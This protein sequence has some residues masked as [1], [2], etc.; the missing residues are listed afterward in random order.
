MSD[1]IRKQDPA[2]PG[3]HV[4][5]WLG[6]YL[7]GE[8]TAGM[9][10][11]IEAHLLNCV[12]CQT[13]LESL[14]QLSDLLHADPPLKPQGSDRAFARKIVEQIRRPARPFWQRFLQLSWRMA[15]LFLF[16]GWAFFQAV[17]WISGLVLVGMNWVPGIED[18]WQAMA[19]LPNDGGLLFSKL[20]SDLLRM[21]LS[22]LKIG[23]VAESIAWLEPVGVM[24]LLNLALLTILAVL[25]VSWLASLWAYQ[26][27]KTNLKED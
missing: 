24:A 26:Q 11:Q 1:L 25:F 5:P 27:A 2:N 21:S 3:D 14:E 10:E 4:T 19:P 13:E 8:V 23:E 6:A 17:E 16:V 9:R 12:H 15:P 22:S 7:D 20:L 18:S